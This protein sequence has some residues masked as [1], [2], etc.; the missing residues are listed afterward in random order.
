[1]AALL[2]V[3]LIGLLIGTTPAADEQT[4]QEH[5]LRTWVK[6]HPR[7][8]GAGRP[9][10]RMGYE[11]SY[12]YDPASRLLVRYGGHNQGGGGEQNS[13]VW[14]YDLDHDDWE[15]RQPNDAPPGVCCAQQN[16]FHD[17]LGRFVR[18][19]AFSASHGW[20]S[21]RE[22]WLKDSSV[23]TYDPAGGRWQ[24]RRPLPEPAVRPLRG[25]AYDPDHQVIVVHGGEGAQHGTLAYDLYTNTWHWLEPEGGPDRDLS[26]PGFAY[27]PVHRVFVLFGSQ[28]GSD[29]K[30]WLYD[31]RR[32]AWRVLETPSHPPADKS[33]PV[34][35]ADTRNGIVLASVLGEG[36]LETWSLDVGK[37]EWKQ[38]DVAD[39]SDEAGPEPSGSRNRVLLYLP[40]RNL[41][42]L[43]NRTRDEQQIWTFRY[44]E[45]PLPAPRPQDVRVAVR[46]DGRTAA[47]RWSPPDQ[48]GPYRYTV[49]RG[50]GERAWEVDWR[51]VVRGHGSTTL[52]DPIEPGTVTWYRVHAVAADGPE[53]AASPLVR[54]QPAAVEGVL[55]SVIN[56]RQVELSWQPLSAGDV[57]GYHVERAEV[58]VYSID[59]PKGIKERL[60]PTSDQAVGR[61]RQVGP[62]RRLTDRPLPMPE[63]TDTT[64]ELTAGQAEAIGEPLLERSLRPDQLD[65][66]GK[67][68]R[69]AVYAYRVRAVNRAGVEGGPSAAVFTIP[70][71]VEQVFAREVDQG[72]T[73]LRWKESPEEGVR[74]YHVYRHDGRFRDSPIVRLTPRPI[75]GTSFLDEAAGTTIRRYEV[76]AVDAL[77]QEGLPSQPVWSHREWQRF[78][79]PYADEWHQ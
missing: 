41:F 65:P 18:F 11:T 50:E 45:A 73:R 7:P 61:I 57:V 75:R 76:V 48:A 24:N 77:G 32:N 69:H 79:E 74:G 22:V 62:F 55:A 34:L 51:P 64:I 19:P 10:P 28:F 17:A 12:G 20:Q 15:L 14:T 27:N 4:A 37:A 70:S 46:P 29:P 71:A 9:S 36:G 23:W 21:L 1:M 67:P 72:A 8:G 31:L 39:Q 49:Y 42:L 40:D 78:Y 44:A 6:R 38:L 56:P 59:Q 60:E 53:G 35:A 63:F 68:Y 52:T 16:V 3:L 43:E 13:E 58:L 66:E 2:I 26:Q 54:T 5:P 30:T 25:A 33:S 47:L